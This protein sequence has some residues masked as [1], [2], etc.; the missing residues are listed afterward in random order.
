VGHGGACFIAGTQV[1]TPDGSK[2]IEDLKVGEEVM[3]FDFK[4]DC[5]VPAP[6]EEVFRH[7]HDDTRSVL[8][9]S[10]TRGN[11]VYVTP[12]HLLYTQRGWVMAGEVT[13]EDFLAAPDTK[14]FL[15][16]LVITPLGGTHAVYNIHVDHP[17]HNYVADGILAHNVKAANV[18]AKGTPGM[19]I[20]RP[21]PILVGEGGEPEF[22]T[23]TPLS[24]MASLSAPNAGSWA[25]LSTSTLAS[26]GVGN[27]PP[28]SAYIQHEVLVKWDARGLTSQKKAD[29]GDE[30]SKRIADQYGVNR[31]TA[32]SIPGTRVA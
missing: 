19:W 11:T 30:I 8:A 32:P 31:L 3:V 4:Q 13:V 14:E 23:V 27:A 25:A 22:L 12:E 6:I 18:F 24:K 26:P 10:T 2:S 15:S 1:N 29:I 5:L 17:D 21:T 28:T 7:E 16:V 9:V 20:S